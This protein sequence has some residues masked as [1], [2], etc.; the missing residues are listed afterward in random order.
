MSTAPSTATVAAVLLLACFALLMTAPV[1]G[2]FSNSD[3]PRH[4]LN[5]L[6]VRDFLAAHPLHNPAGWAIDYYLKRPAL[7]ILFY[8]PLFYGVEAIAFT[9]FGFSHIVAQSIIASYM[10]LLAVSSYGLA[11]QLLPRWSALGAALLV[12]GMPETA[13]WGRQVMLD[14]PAYSLI[15]TSAW[16]LSLYIRFNRPHT[17]YLAGAFLLAAIYTKYNS[18]FVAPA[19]AAGFFTARGRQGFRDRH[20]LIAVALVALGMVPVAFLILKYGSRNL[21]SVSGFAGMLP[22]NSLDCWLFY[23]R[24]LPGQI[25]LVPLALAAGGLIPLVM[26]TRRKAPNEAGESGAGQNWLAVLLLV[27]LAVGYLFYSLISLKETR[28]TIMVFLPLAF[29]AP[30]FLY[31]LLPKNFGEFAGLAL[32][33]STLAYTLLI[34]PVMRVDGYREVASYL[35]MH[36]PDDGLVA[37]FGYRDA[38]LIFDLSDIPARNDIAVVRIDKLLLSAPVGDQRR[39]VKQVNYTEAGLAE[40]LRGSGVSYFVAQPGFWSEFEVM[41]RFDRIIHGPDY[42]KVAHFDITG[43]LS[44]Q[45]GVGGVD[46]FRPTYP[47]NKKSAPVSID[48]PFLGQRFV[49]TPGK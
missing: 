24:A 17:I 23:L 48:M 32:G 20:A 29:A 19:L 12:I 9:L 28:D 42:E 45:D 6:F 37:Y 2:N 7:T 26:R 18:G 46:I 30:L 10:L 4:A 27:W 5:G 15:V 35:A 8:P 43:D 49:G 13:N 21:E 47:V 36:A 1:A 44:T 16:C 25:G 38:N 41:A 14:I 11:R 34:Y 40:M 22:L 33:V 31:Q 39:G 3:A